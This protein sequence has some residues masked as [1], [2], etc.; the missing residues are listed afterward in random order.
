MDGRVIVHTICFIMTCLDYLWNIYSIIWWHALLRYYNFTTWWQDDNSVLIMEFENLQ[1]RSILMILIVGID[2]RDGQDGKSSFG[3][4]LLQQNWTRSQKKYKEFKLQGCERSWSRGSRNIW[5]IY[6]WNRWR[7][8]WL[9]NIS[10]GQ[11]ILPPKEKCSV[12]KIQ[13]L[14]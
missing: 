10:K 11:R 2:L 12:W 7:S 14:E 6:V 3:H 4:I 9:D 1:T 13:I 8:K 5:T